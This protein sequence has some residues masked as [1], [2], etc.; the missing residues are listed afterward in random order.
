MAQSSTPIVSGPGSLKFE[1][2]DEAHLDHLGH[3]MDWFLFM[4]SDDIFQ[5]KRHDA[6]EFA[7]YHRCPS[8]EPVG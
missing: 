3:R 2:E 1:F 4:Q 6:S 8:L 5:W 7:L